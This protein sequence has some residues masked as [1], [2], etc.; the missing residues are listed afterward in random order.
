MLQACRFDSLGDVINDPSAQALRSF[1]MQKM[2]EGVGHRLQ[3]LCVIIMFCSDT[4]DT[5][6]LATPFVREEVTSVTDLMKYSGD[7]YFA[8][9]PLGRLQ[10]LPVPLGPAS[11]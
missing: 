10:M 3:Q 4:I 6:G 5:N 11:C 7:Q 8:C 1:N 2:R 9:Q